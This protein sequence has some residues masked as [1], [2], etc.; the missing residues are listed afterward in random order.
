MQPKPADKKSSR[1]APDAQL[2]WVVDQIK[3]DIIF[4]RLRPREHL[5]EEQLN[6]RFGGSRHQ[7]R[8][9]LVELERMGLVT[10]RPNKGAIVREFTVAEVDGMYELRAILHRGAS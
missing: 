4:G 5:I 2:A 6:A 10:R 9:A 3:Q 1:A 8:S 7:L